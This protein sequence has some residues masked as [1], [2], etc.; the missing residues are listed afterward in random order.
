MSIRERKDPKEKIV[1]R[2]SAVNSVNNSNTNAKNRV[3]ITTKNIKIFQLC[4]I[5]AAYFR[6]HHLLSF[7][8]HGS[9]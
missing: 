9:H 5:A 7:N 4:I 8:K 3:I 6:T 1:L 2:T